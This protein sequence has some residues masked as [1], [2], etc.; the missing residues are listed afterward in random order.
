MDA[1]SPNHMPMSP[2]V[3]LTPETVAKNK[4]RAAALELVKLGDELSEN[5]HPELKDL[6][7][8]MSDAALAAIESSLDSGKL[9]PEG[10]TDFMGRFVF[11]A[12]Q[13]QRPT[14]RE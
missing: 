1:K 12:L 7:R 4:C 3:Q 6:Y 5:G 11:N 13:R 10:A 8:A 9:T 2:D 14:T